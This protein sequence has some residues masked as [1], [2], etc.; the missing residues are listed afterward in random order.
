V[1]GLTQVAVSGLI[2]SGERLGDVFEGGIAED[3][4]V[5]ANVQVPDVAAPALVDSALHPFL[6]SRDYE[7]ESRGIKKVVI[8]KVGPIL[9]FSGRKN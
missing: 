5:L 1:E 2:R 6:E 8:K 4:A 9:F 3:R 7:L